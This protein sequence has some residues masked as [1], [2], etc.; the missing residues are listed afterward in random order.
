[1]DRLDAVDLIAQTPRSLEF[2]PLRGFLHALGEIVDELCP[3]AFQHLDRIAHILAVVLWC[4][5][6]Y[7]G[8]GTTLD[9]MLQTRSGAV[10]EEAV[11]AGAQQ[12][13]LLQEQQGFPSRAS[14]RI[15]AEEAPCEFAAAAIE[16]DARILL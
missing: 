7:T 13:Q 12:K 14:V 16:A 4:D 9:L 3:L 1:M 15:R 2:E 10:R 5:E 8:T 6:S 11:A